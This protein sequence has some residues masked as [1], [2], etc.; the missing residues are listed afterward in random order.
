MTHWWELDET[1]AD[2]QLIQPQAVAYYPSGRR[3]GR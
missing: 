2:L 1:G 3:T